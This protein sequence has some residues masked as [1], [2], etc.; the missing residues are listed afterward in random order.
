MHNPSNPRGCVYSRRR[1]I[2]QFVQRRY[3][4]VSLGSGKG[5][6]ALIDLLSNPLLKLTGRREFAFLRAEKTNAKPWS[7]FPIRNPVWNRET[8][9]ARESRLYI[10]RRC[11]EMNLSIHDRRKGS[12]RFEHLCWRNTK[13]VG[14]SFQPWNI[15]VSRSSVYFWFGLFLRGKK[16]A[17]VLKVVLKECLIFDFE[18]KLHPRFYFSY[19]SRGINVCY[20]CF[21]LI[22]IAQKD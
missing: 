18:T 11:C 10:R 5:D 14:E 2:N 9:E 17:R 1:W 12:S 13:R 21:L 6:P 15:T 16:P 3:D 7:S 8:W 20:L 22:L 19:F 4:G